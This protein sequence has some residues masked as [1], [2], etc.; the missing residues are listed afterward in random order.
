MTSRRASPGWRP[1][2]AP[3]GPPPGGG[4]HHYHFELMAIRR[5]TLDLSP[6]ASAA[7]VLHAAAPYAIGR[8]ELV[9]TYRR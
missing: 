4:V 7:D 8:I 6:A 9:G 2:T 1:A 5:P 3:A